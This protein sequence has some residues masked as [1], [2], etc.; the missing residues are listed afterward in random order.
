[1]QNKTGRHENDFT[2]HDQV[3]GFFV[4]AFGFWIPPIHAPRFSQVAQGGT[5]I[6]AENGSNASKTTV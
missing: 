2:V 5:V 1:M 6:L 3:A 4:Y